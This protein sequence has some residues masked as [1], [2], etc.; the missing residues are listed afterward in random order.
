LAQRK[1]LCARMGSAST[2]LEASI[3]SP[4]VHPI[5]D[6]QADIDLRRCGLMRDFGVG[7]LTTIRHGIYLPQ[8]G[9]NPSS[10]FPTR[11]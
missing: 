8:S 5:A 7:V 3:T 1:P 6:I 2:K 10:P 9:E 11:A 4:L